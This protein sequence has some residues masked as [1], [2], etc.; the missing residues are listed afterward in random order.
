MSVFRKGG[1]KQT[2]IVA[3]YIVRSLAW[4]APHELLFSAYRSND[5][6]F[7]L[8]VAGTD[9]QIRLL[10]RFPYDFQIQ[11]VSKQQRYLLKAHHE[12]SIVM[13]QPTHGNESD[14]R[15]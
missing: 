14:V 15:G 4:L 12:Q 1:K 7:G 6:D 9:K 5:D 8:F 13:F 11:D 2:S 3:G 10:T